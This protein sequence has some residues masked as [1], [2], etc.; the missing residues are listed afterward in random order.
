MATL[1]RQHSTNTSRRRGKHTS[2]ERP[3]VNTQNGSL[4]AS[5]PQFV[6]AAA[7]TGGLLV[8]GLLVR[9]FRGKK[10]PQKDE[11]KRTDAASTPETSNGTAASGKPAPRRKRSGCVIPMSA[12]RGMSN[13]PETASV[14]IRQPVTSNDHLKFYADSFQPLLQRPLSPL[15]PLDTSRHAESRHQTPPQVQPNQRASQ[16]CAKQS[17]GLLKGL[18]LPKALYCLLGPISQPQSL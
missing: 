16:L 15:L 5:K 13:L 18:D 9:K 2:K 10:R 8:T 3:P 4:G 11:R 12:D 17:Q 7:V 6:V 14:S 1:P